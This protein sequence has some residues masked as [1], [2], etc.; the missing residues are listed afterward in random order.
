MGIKGTDISK[1]AADVVLLDNP[2]DSIVTACKYGRI[3]YDCIRKFIQFQLTNNIFTVFI[4]FLG[5]L[6]A[7]QIL[8]VNLIMD[9][10]TSLALATEYRSYS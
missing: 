3:I 6:N 8:W 7:I 4:T 5:P 10:F 2:L 9:S 1:D